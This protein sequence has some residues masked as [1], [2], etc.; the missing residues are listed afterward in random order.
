MVRGTTLIQKTDVFPLIQVRAL[1]RYPKP[2]NGGIPAQPTLRT[3]LGG[4]LTGPF[5]RDSGPV[6]SPP[7][8]RTPARCYQRKHVYFSRSSLCAY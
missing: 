8:T 7:V 1:R 2:C 5:D 6:I 3:K 4:Q